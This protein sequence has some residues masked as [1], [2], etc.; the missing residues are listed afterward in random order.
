MWLKTLPARIE[1]CTRIWQLSHLSPMENLTY[2][3]VMSGQRGGIPIILKIGIE[4]GA[5][6]N[7]ACCLTSFDGHGC[8]KMLACDFSTGALLLERAAPGD[9]LKLFFPDQERQ[10]LQA[11]SMI[12]Q[13]LQQAPQQHT[14]F[15]TIADW[16]EI[17][18]YTWDLPDAHLNKAR[19]L[20][21]C[22]LATQGKPFLLHGDL[23]HDNIISYGKNWIAIDPKGVVGETAYEIG[24][25]LRNPIPDLN[26]H[27]YAQ[28]IINKRIQEFAEI[29]NLD[30]QRVAGWNYVQA[31]LSACWMI[32]DNLSPQPFLDYLEIIAKD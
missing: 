20:K 8:I 23:H 25:Y 31:V 29:L 30:P 13:A 7:E 16:L 6:K 9:S 5:L 22:L 10:A 3:Y 26:H 27:P 15:P 1:H 17:L 11:V 24:A 12:I 21:N 28:S 2:H 4:P 14:S 18:D 19:Y 32:A